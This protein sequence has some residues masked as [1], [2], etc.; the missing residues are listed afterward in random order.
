[1]LSLI[2]TTRSPSTLMSGFV[3]KIPSKSATLNLLS[4]CSNLNLHPKLL[5]LRLKVM[6]GFEILLLKNYE[7]FGP[8]KLFS[9]HLDFDFTW[10]E[11]LAFFIVN[12]IEYFESR[13]VLFCDWFFAC[14]KIIFNFFSFDVQVDHQRI[15]F[16]FGFSDKV[17]RQLSLLLIQE[18]NILE[19][20]FHVLVMD[21]F[22][23]ALLTKVLGAL[24]AV[25]LELFVVVF[26]VAQR[27][28]FID[29][30][31]FVSGHQFGFVVLIAARV[32]KE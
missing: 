8:L 30:F 2:P 15:K 29:G 28:D 12:F 32:A 27:V 9:E 4:S 5:F 19:R 7:S 11:L 23:D 20:V 26:T 24:D 31:E 6:Q 3:R 10:V 21:S 13:L 18:T 17:L 25:K 22:L 1:M 14:I 16:F